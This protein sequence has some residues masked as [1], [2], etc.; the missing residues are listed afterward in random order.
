MSTAVQVRAAV[1][2]ALEEAGISVAQAYEKEKFSPLASP[3]CV[4]GERSAVIEAAGMLDY[5]GE[6]WNEERGSV[7]EVYGKAWR[8]TLSL[9]VFAS[10]A[11]GAAVCGK[12]SEDVTAALLRHLP[13]GLAVEELSWEESRW[14]KEYGL[15]LRRGSAK[16]SAYFLAAAAEDETVVSDFIL[17]GVVKT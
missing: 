7:E 12:V 15:F 5:L 6:R 11:A 8:L 16:F 1:Q 4:I 14:D 2:A 17:K 3:L 9:D 13:S 10:R